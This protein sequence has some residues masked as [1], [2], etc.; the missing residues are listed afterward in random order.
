[1]IDYFVNFE[2]Q[3]NNLGTSNALI[4]RK[5][6]VLKYPCSNTSKCTPYKITLSPGTYKIECW[7]SKGLKQREHGKAG[8]GAYTR[9]SFAVFKKTVL[10]GYVGASGSFNSIGIVAEFLTH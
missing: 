6:I 3:Y 2:L 9:G 4:K 1:M 7:G 10:Y 8:L 5:H